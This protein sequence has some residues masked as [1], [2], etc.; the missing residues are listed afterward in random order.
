MNRAVLIFLFIGMLVSSCEPAATATQPVVD[1]SPEDPS[2]AR[3]Q[4]NVIHETILYAGPGNI[5]FQIL[6]KLQPG[7][8]LFPLGS[9]FDFVKVETSEGLS[10]FVVKTSL[11]N[12][13]PDLPKLGTNE[14]PWIYYNAIENFVSEATTF[15]NENILIRDI[16][17]TGTNIEGGSR[18]L[19]SAF[20]I[21]TA[22]SLKDTGTGYANVQLIGTPAII[23]ENWW[24]EYIR[25]DVGVNTQGNLQ[26]CLRDGTSQNCA[27][28]KALSMR[29]D[30]PF[31]IVF[32]DPQGKTFH[33]LDQQGIETLMIRVTNQKGVNLPN[34][35]FPDQKVW[36]GAWVGEQTSLLVSS[37][38]F[39]RAPSGKWDTVVGDAVH[40]DLNPVIDIEEE[41]IEVVDPE[42]GARPLWS[43]G[44]S[45][46]ARQGEDVFVSMIEKQ[47]GWAVPNNV[48]CVI[49]KRTNTG[50]QMER[51]F[52]EATREPCP[53]GIDDKNLYVSTNPSLGE[54]SQPAVVT[55]D[56][57]NL[58][59]KLAACRSN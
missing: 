45:V 55:L 43:R 16:N 46:I 52:D 59:N 4:V 31:S 24:Q 49:Y 50:W 22:L 58:D 5:S 56:K 33:I 26:I 35:L 12:I 7:D 19:D 23:Q 41:F 1:N 9:Y 17:N 15:E 53:I 28:E 8:I 34:G 51:L 20:R 48:K 11:D 6:S 25:M 39:E 2:Q 14:V 37:F 3:D 13:P 44:S 42:N 36:L 21:R 38:T 40:L 18:H 47:G 10:G 29:A 57:S 54:L 30:E 27:F 32:D